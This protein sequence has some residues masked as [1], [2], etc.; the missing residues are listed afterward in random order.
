MPAYNSVVRGYFNP[1]IQ[2]FRGFWMVTWFKKQFGH[3]EEKI[4][5]D[6]GVPTERVLDKSLDD[7]PAGSNGLMLQ[8]YWAPGLK[9]PEAKG[10]I[11]GFNDCHTKAHVYKS[12]VEG[13]GYALY[14]GM[15][16][17]EKKSGQKINKISVSDGGSQSDAICKIT[18]DM[19]GKP[20]YRVQTFE[21][22]GLGAAMIAFVAKGEFKNF[23]E[24]N[25]AMVHF[26]DE[27]KPNMQ[28]HKIYKNLF[29]KV[30][31]DIYP[32]LRPLYLKL[33]EIVNEETNEI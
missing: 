29:N 9:I 19:F 20:V 24:C 32:Q 25:K 21:T 14:E 1:E 11:I 33:Y 15:V 12:I 27:F 22:S 10:T 5:E 16:Y 7:I 8:P 13:I 30:Y 6:I 17:L 26:K 18:A 4:A 3:E 2:I 31:K 23:E 28:N